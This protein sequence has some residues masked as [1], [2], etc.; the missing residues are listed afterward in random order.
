MSSLLEIQAAVIAALR[1]DPS[2]TAIVGERVWDRAPHA[3]TFPLIELGFRAQEPWDG[4]AMNG[5]ET[6]VTVNCWSEQPGAVEACRIADAV[7]ARLH[8]Q[9]LSL[10]NNAFVLG[11]FIGLN[12]VPQGDGVTT[13]AAIRFRFLTHD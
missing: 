8:E 13:L 6:V 3:A 7:I 5:A 11:R 9:A 1:A 12:V 2:V 4:D 10:P